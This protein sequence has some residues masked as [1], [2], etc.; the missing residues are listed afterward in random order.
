M[1]NQ[2]P[3]YV[4]DDNTFYKYAEYCHEN[5][6]NCSIFPHQQ[7]YADFVWMSSIQY[8][9]S[10]IDSSMAPYLATMLNNLTNLSPYWDYPYVFWELLLPISKSNAHSSIEKKQRS[11]MQSI[12]LWEKGKKFNC[13][14]EKVKGILSLSEREFYDAYNQKNETWEKLLNPCDDY[15]IPWYLWFNYFY[16]MNNWEDSSQDYKLAAFSPKSP[17]VYSYMSALVSSRKWQHIKS[18]K[19]WFS[20]FLSFQQKL[21][22]LEN[23]D[24]FDFYMQK[25]DDAF[26]KTVFEYQLYIINESDKLAQDDP[27]C[28][29]NYECLVSK[30]HIKETL[31]KELLSCSM[32][33]F[34]DFDIQEVPWFDEDDTEFE[35]K[36]KCMCIIYWL[37]NELINI[38][39]GE[40]NYPFHEENE[41]FEFIRHEENQSWWVHVPVRQQAE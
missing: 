21:V 3:I 16:Y 32:Y 30:N 31:E 5:Q 36:I 23:E 35:Q 29:H 26:K 7:I 8:I 17:T 28:F 11:R 6:I 20:R 9:G 10:I 39:T 1:K 33:N 37:E 19:M 27:E 38:D 15:E 13:D 18:M 41:T 34:D 24:E 14:E 2:D 25:V 40:M 4:W 22:N 12:E